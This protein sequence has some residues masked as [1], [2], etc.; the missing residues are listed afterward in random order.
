MNLVVRYHITIYCFFSRN[1][2][3]RMKWDAIQLQKLLIFCFPII[4]Y[5]FFVY[6][7]SDF[8]CHSWIYSV[9]MLAQR[10]APPD[11]QCKDKFLVQGTVISP[12]TSEEDI[13]S[14]VVRICSCCMLYR[15]FSKIFVM[16]GSS[17]KIVASILKRRSWRFF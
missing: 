5:F 13:T 4:V 8:N 11:M 16:Q 1:C 10:T 15:P 6:L 14:D 2:Q 17:Q 7:F 3:S 12:G 9:T